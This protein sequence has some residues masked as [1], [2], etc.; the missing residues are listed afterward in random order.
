MARAITTAVV[1]KS[2]TATIQVARHEVTIEVCQQAR[3]IAFRFADVPATFAV[4]FD[5]LRDILQRR[6]EED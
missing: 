4:T 6:H 2:G 3:S 5:E 1:G